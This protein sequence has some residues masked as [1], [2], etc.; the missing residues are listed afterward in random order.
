VGEKP[1]DRCS[2]AVESLTVCMRFITDLTF[3]SVPDVLRNAIGGSAGFV[4]LAR[5]F[6]ATANRIYSE[7]RRTCC[8]QETSPVP[9]FQRLERVTALIAGASYRARAYV[10]QEE[11][12]IRLVFTGLEHLRGSVLNAAPII[13]VIMGMIEAVGGRAVPL[14]SRDGLR[15]APRSAYRVYPDRIEGDTLEVVV[16]PPEQA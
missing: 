8:P 9:L 11:G 2:Q 4:L 16:V 15:H 3:Y 6:A 14:T 7:V 5:I 1:T 13:G 10:R 12:R